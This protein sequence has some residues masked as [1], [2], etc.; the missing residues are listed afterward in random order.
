[1]DHGGSGGRPY[2]LVVEGLLV[3]VVVAVKHPVRFG[4]AS[5]PPL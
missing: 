5:Q 2:L 3:G 4:L 1:M